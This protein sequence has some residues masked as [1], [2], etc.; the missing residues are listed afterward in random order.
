MNSGREGLHL[1]VDRHVVDL[2]P[3]L[4]QQLL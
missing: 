1:P 2:D 3:A 4:G